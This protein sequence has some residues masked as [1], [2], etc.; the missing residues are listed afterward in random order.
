MLGGDWSEHWMTGGDE[1]HGSTVDG[2]RAMV[3]SQG[4]GD[5]FS[6]DLSHFFTAGNDTIERDRLNIY[7]SITMGQEDGDILL[8]EW[9]TKGKSWENAAAMIPK[10]SV[11]EIHLQIRSFFEELT[12]S[13]TQPSYNFNQD[14]SQHARLYQNLGQET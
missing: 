1:D 10:S 4:D 5:I 8:V 14:T 7:Y 6:S 3:R 9:L 2:S 12:D 11:Q 13:T